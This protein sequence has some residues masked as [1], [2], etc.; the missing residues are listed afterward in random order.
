MGYLKAIGSPYV[1][2]AVAVASVLWSLVAVV[3]CLIAQ[4]GI[5]LLPEASPQT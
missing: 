4:V 2:I 5:H 1:L 3:V